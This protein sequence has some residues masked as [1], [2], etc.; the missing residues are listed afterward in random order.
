MPVE[1]DE[2]R[3]SGTEVEAVAGLVRAHPPQG[4]L[5]LVRVV[6]GGLS[7]LIVTWRALTGEQAPEAYEE[8]SALKQAILHAG[9]VVDLK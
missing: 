9:E 2:I 1:P 3:L 4:D 8:P 6:E 7:T 5:K